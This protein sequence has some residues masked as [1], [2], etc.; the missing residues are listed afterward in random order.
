MTMC[1][2]LNLSLAEVQQS[3]IDF[4]SQHCHLHYL[5]VLSYAAPKI[6]RFFAQETFTE[7][8]GNS[9]GKKAPNF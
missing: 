3:P 9:R 1:L 6:L 5:F 8:I 7:E 4:G 2:T